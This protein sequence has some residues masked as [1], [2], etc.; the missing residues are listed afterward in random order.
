MCGCAVCFPTSSQGGGSLSRAGIGWNLIQTSW[1]ASPFP[2]SPLCS[3]FLLGHFL[4][5]QF[6]L[7]AARSSWPEFRLPN[8]PLLNSLLC[9]RFFQAQFSPP[10]FP[11]VLRR[12]LLSQ[13]GMCSAETPP[14]H[15]LSWLLSQISI[16]SWVLV[17]P[18][19]LQHLAKDLLGA[20]RSSCG[21][22]GIQ[23][24][25]PTVQEL[26][27]DRI[28]SYVR[29]IQSSLGSQVRSRDIPGGPL[30][31]WDGSTWRRGGSE[32]PYFSLKIHDRRLNS[33]GGWEQRTG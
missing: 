20:I 33:G 4:S 32:S 27:D 6:P 10:R 9:S 8:F 31:R 30:G 1:A 3:R 2:D 15:G 18:K 23:V 24:G 21:A 26:R 14:N 5:S 25:Q 22:M 28:E 12:F 16:N 7:C 17:Y 19:R 29:S 13:T 11:P